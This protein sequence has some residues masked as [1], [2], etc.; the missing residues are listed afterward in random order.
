MSALPPKADIATP[1][2]E[3]DIQRRAFPPAYC[4][5]LILIKLLIHLLRS[6][7]PLSHV[8]MRCCQLSGS[9]L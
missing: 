5:S 1:P 6:N 8:I 3:A 2:L 9:L 7:G 4:C